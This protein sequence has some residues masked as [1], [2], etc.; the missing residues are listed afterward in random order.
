[1]T[2]HIN[3]FRTEVLI[4]QLP[5]FD[6]QVAYN[7][8]LSNFS[9][10]QRTPSS[11]AMLLSQSSP[12]LRTGQCAVKW[13]CP[14][15]Q[16]EYLR[17]VIPAS[18]LP[19]EISWGFCCNHLA[20]QFLHLPNA[21]FLIASLIEALLQKALLHFSPEALLNKPPTCKPWSFKVSLGRI[22]PERV[23]IKVDLWSYS[24]I[25]F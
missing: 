7:W 18:D 19:V 13:P 11:K 21:V 9:E 24:K 20:I 25:R 1:M 8:S 17:R 6:L 15:V 22:K 3:P 23:D 5:G 14:L 2:T 10:L 12:H 16:L 4:P